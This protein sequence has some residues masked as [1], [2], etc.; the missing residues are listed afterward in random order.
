M[1]NLF[2]E[3]DAV[4]RKIGDGWCSQE[5][6]HL[7][8][9][10]IVAIRP[11]WVVEIGV[12][13]GRSLL[14]MAAA[15]RHIGHGKVIGIDPWQPQASSEGMTGQDLKWWGSVDHEKIYQAFAANLRALDLTQWVDVIRKRSDDV[16]LDHLTPGIGFLHLDGNHSDQ[17][18]KD[19]KRFAGLIEN[20]GL[21]FCDDLNWTGG[22]VIKAVARLE[23]MGF[24]KLLDL[25]TGALFKKVSA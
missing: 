23:K 11:A 20:G 3:V 7:L 16:C 18:D 9:V 14:P 8:A 2:S 22:G 19:V 1:S 25:D 13:G 4:W 6:A 17:A 12:W 10:S 24:Q 5:K 21:I 15:C